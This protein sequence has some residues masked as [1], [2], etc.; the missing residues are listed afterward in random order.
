MINPKPEAKRVA[1]ANEDDKNEEE[2]GD[3]R[4]CAPR[5]RDHGHRGRGVGSCRGSTESVVAG[6]HVRRQAVGVETAGP[7]PGED[8][9]AAGWW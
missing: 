9:S 8:C 7:G 2:E 4:S 3:D 6:Q 1:I 5:R